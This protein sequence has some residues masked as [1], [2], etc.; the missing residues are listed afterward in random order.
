MLG[1][2]YSAGSFM[3]GVIGATGATLSFVGCCNVGCG[4]VRTCQG[5]GEGCLMSSDGDGE[6]DG[7]GDMLD[8][9]SSAIE[10]SSAEAE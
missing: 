4:R 10:N 6:S 1:L 9:G 2:A 3:V 8:D 5:S 7:D